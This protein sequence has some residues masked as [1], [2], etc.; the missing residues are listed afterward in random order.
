MRVCVCVGTRRFLFAYMQ[1]R[2]SVAIILRE[3]VQPSEGFMLGLLLSSSSPSCG[4]FHC[5]P[6]HTC[7]QL[8]S[9]SSTSPSSWTLRSQ[10]VLLPASVSSPAPP[11]L[12]GAALG[13]NAGN[14]GK[15]G[16]KPD[17]RSCVPV[18][19]F[20]SIHCPPSSTLPLFFHHPV[21]LLLLLTFSSSY[22]HGH[23]FLPYPAHL[24]PARRLCNAHRPLP[25]QDRGK[26]LCAPRGLLAA[27]EVVGG[28]C[29]LLLGGGVGRV[30]HRWGDGHAGECRR[31][32]EAQDCKQ[33]R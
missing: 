9:T 24:G 8:P 21:A 14:A 25:A 29:W 18:T 10:S 12:G 28:Q 13:G 27:V 20:L 4:C 31:G 33:G 30:R 3:K 6:C 32:W 1:G 2:S 5:T 15:V 17:A 22:L 19:V 7:F 26:V 11:P 16:A 23:V